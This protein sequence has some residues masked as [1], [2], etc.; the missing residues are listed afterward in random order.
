MGRGGGREKVLMF[1]YTYPVSN[2]Q[3]GIFT[4]EMFLRI[5]LLT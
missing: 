4:G 2:V 1:S 5:S 3:Q